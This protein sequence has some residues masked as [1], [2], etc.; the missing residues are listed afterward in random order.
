MPSSLV[1][2]SLSGHALCYSFIKRLDC[3]LLPRPHSPQ[4]SPNSLTRLGASASAAVVFSLSL[5]PGLSCLPSQASSQPPAPA[6]VLWIWITCLAPSGSNIQS[7]ARQGQWLPL[8][9]AG[10]P[11]S[12]PRSST[13]G[14]DYAA[15]GPVPTVHSFLTCLRA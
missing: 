7:R 9:G 10:R 5:S 14:T 13:R 6:I 11:Y 2:T 4:V 12:A 15:P 1:F 8:G 3:I